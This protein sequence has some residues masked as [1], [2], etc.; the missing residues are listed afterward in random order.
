M[1]G[2]LVLARRITLAARR[3]PRR[4][5]RVAAALLAGLTLL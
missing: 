3:R 5:V 1:A 2:V 4:S